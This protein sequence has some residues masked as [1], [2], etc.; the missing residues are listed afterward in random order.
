MYYKIKLNITSYLVSE[1]RIKPFIDFM[2]RM[3]EPDSR[4]NPFEETEEYYKGRCHCPLMP[5]VRRL[6]QKSQWLA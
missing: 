6:G 2:V 5:G 4:T 3:W 1:E